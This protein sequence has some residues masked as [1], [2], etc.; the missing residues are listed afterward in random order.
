MLSKQN[1]FFKR[2]VKNTKLKVEY[3]CFNILQ[4]LNVFYN[5]KKIVGLLMAYFIVKCF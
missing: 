3:S 4:F 1:I 2:V 5:F